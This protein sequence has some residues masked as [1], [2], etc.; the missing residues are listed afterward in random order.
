M[1]RTLM[2]ISFHSTRFF[3]W[4]LPI[5]LVAFVSWLH[6]TRI[7]RIKA[8]SALPDWSV[9]HPEPSSTTATGFRGDTRR[10]VWPNGDFAIK[11]AVEAAQGEHA[12]SRSI[13]AAALRFFSE[14]RVEHA[15]L[16]FNSACYLILGVIGAVLLGLTCGTRAAQFFLIFF[17]GSYPLIAAFVPG[18]VG[19]LELFSGFVSSG[20]TEN[21]FLSWWRR[22]GL[23]SPLFATALPMILVAGLLAQAVRARASIGVLR[24]SAGLSL[25]AVFLALWRV[26]LFG[27][28]DLI[29]AI[30]LGVA[31]SKTRP[32]SRWWW[33]SPLTLLPGIILAWPSPKTPAPGTFTSNEWQALVLRD[34]SHELAAREPHAVVLASPAVSA[35]LAYAGGLNTLTE[36]GIASADTIMRIC[37]STTMEEAQMLIN[38]HHVRYLVFVTW[39]P[40]FRVDANSRANTFIEQLHRWNLPPWLRAIPYLLPSISGRSTDRVVILSVVPEQDEAGATANLAEYFLESGDFSRAQVLLPELERFPTDLSAIVAQIQIELAA[41][42]HAISSEK[43]RTLR[44]AVEAQADQALTLP[45]QIELAL[46]LARA[47]ADDLARPIISECANNLTAADALNLSPRNLLRFFALCHYYKRD[48]ADQ[49]V[50]ALAWRLLPPGSQQKVRGY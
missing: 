38:A 10:I 34:L 24:L 14:S 30:A 12:G 9:P 49:K 21:S 2:S 16:Y 3:G 50:D 22:D 45:Q 31:V 4:V 47:N 43:I 5:L 11:R 19:I 18:R 42:P 8:L 41:N 46:V 29:V 25:V 28:A 23:S 44:E 1:R 48:L 13:A 33:L 17:F 7:E 35:D 39:D 6:F 26:P 32:F 36:S 40:F 27:L 37:Q 15:A 20:V